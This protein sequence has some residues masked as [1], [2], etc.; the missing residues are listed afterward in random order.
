MPT[1]VKVLQL[2]M[3]VR[4]IN[5]TRRCRD[6]LIM[7]IIDQKTPRRIQVQRGETTVLVVVRSRPAAALPQRGHWRRQGLRRE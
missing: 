5:S 3:G 1:T 7:M 4:W 6:I 2:S